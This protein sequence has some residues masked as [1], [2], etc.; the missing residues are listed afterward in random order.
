MQNK[1]ELFIRASPDYFFVR[2]ERNSRIAL[3]ATGTAWREAM[4]PKP[5]SLLLSCFPSEC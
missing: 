5:C 4:S 2:L 3:E 1:D